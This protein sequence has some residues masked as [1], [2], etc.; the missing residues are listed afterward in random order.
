ANGDRAAEDLSGAVRFRL[1]GPGRHA[2]RASR[3]EAR[4]QLR[5]RSDLPGSVPIGRRV[6]AGAREVPG[7]E[8]RDPGALRF[9]AGSE[10]RLPEIR[11][12]LPRGVLRVDRADPREENTRRRLRPRAG[13]VSPLVRRPADRIVLSPAE[14]RAAI[15]E[16]IA[17]AKREIALSL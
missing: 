6:R 4:H 8:I 13:N 9:A 15:L 10:R 3:S 17:G 2:L 12:V 16:V 5:T 11:P 7:W 1:L 14:C